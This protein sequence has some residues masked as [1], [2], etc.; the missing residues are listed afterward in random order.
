MRSILIRIFLFSLPVCLIL[1]GCQSHKGDFVPKTEAELAAMEQKNQQAHSAFLKGDYKTAEKILRQMATERTVSRPLY[2]LE[3]LSVLLFDGKHQEAHEL[4]KILH[5]DFETLFDRKS[6]E[7]AQSVWHGE[8]NKVYKGDSYERC[9][10]YVLM[11]LSFIEKGQ[12]EDALRC[13]KNGLLADADSTAENSVGDYGLLYYL[14]YFAASK[15][16]DQQ[17]AAEYMRGLYKSLVH[18]DFRVED[19]NGKKKVQHCFEQLS[20]KD[21]NVLLVIWAGAPP[22]VECLGE[23]KH[24]RSVIRGKNPF[25]FMGISL[26]T[27][28]VLPIPNNLGDLD[29]Q[30]TTKGGRLMDNV[31][32][33]KAAAKKAM[34]VSKNVFFVVGTGLVIAGARTMGTLPVGLSLLGAGVGCYVVGGT[35]HIIGSMMNPAADARFWRNIPCQFYIVPLKLPAGKHS[36]TVTGY[37]HFDLA[38]MSVFEVDVKEGS[39]VSVHHLPMMTQ[40]QMIWSATAEKLQNEI[41]TALEKAQGNTMAK[42]L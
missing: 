31:L 3:L 29:F 30:A 8:I 22:T 12:Y 19:Q 15:M 18:R 14:G 25:D 34:E 40:G 41:R 23:Y 16:K 11:A 28:P 33:D 10:F 42:E 13:V 21:H 4:M 20:Q 39:S 35:V 26:L 37:H 17:E 6:E 7:K 36:V 1:C 38:G 5:T 32:A 27:S 2:Q 9:T 24:I